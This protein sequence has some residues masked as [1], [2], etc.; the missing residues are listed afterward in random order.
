[1][2][3]KRLAIIGG[4]PAGL[5]LARYLADRDFKNVTVFEKESVVGGKSLSVTADEAVF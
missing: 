1:M 5:T 4:G 3:G 2:K